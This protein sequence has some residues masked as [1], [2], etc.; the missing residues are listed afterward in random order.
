MKKTSAFIIALFMLFPIAASAAQ[1][2]VLP[3]TP[4]N[5]VLA[6]DS[7]KNTGA[8]DI[9]GGYSFMRIFKHIINANI[10][11]CKKIRLS[12]FFTTLKKS[13]E[14]KGF[15]NSKVKISVYAKDV[16]FGKFKKFMFER[17]YS[18]VGNKVSLNPG[19]G[20][21]ASLCVSFMLCE[22]LLMSVMLALDSKGEEG[23]ISY[24]NTIL[25]IKKHSVEFTTLCFFLCG[26]E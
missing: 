14:I 23:S 11:A 2:I 6:F 24:T 12:D 13:A 18:H 10:E 8:A 4:G 16:I 21:K 9:A 20:I 1:G 15:E 7:A 26:K 25:R 3:V 22:M 19:M 5:G 17:K